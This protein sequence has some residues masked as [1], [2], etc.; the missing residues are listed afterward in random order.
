MKKYQKLNILDK[1]FLIKSKP[2]HNFNLLKK[3]INYQVEK[4]K[5]FFEKK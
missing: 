4:K 2:D 3:Q 5:Y 1:Y